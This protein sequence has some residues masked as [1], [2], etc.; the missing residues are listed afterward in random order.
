MKATN[1]NINEIEKKKEIEL[2]IKPMP[3]RR[4]PFRKQNVYETTGLHKLDDINFLLLIENILPKPILINYFKHALNVKRYKT[5]MP[6]GYSMPPRHQI[7]YTMEDQEIVHPTQKYGE[8]MTT[9]PTHVLDLIPYFMN[10]IKEYIPNNPYVILSTGLDILY[11][12]QFPRGGSIAAHSDY[13]GDPD[14]K[15]GLIIIYS[16][17]QTRYIRIR[18]KDDKTYFNVQM[19]NNSLVCMYGES[20]QQLYTHQVDKLYS[21]E[22]VGCRISLNMRFMKDE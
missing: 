11:S 19:N 18:R 1:I 20:F 3:C 8:I 6:Y 5:S 16:I 14:R 22:E 9:Y 17:G 21:N 13:L 7:C 2:I 15:W 10:R 4:P 12:P